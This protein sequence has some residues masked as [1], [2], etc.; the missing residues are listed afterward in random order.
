MSKPLPEIGT[1]AKVWLPGES[2]WA[3]CVGQLV[4]NMWVGRISND[5]VGT[6]SDAER[7]ALTEQWF[8]E[9]H[10]AL[11]KLHNFKRGDIVVFRAEQGDGYEIWVPHANEG[12]TA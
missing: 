12:G 1:Y 6:M 9:G 3:E 10:R 11:P 7:Q 5:L 4:N 2:P 8:G